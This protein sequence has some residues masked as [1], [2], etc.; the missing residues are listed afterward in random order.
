MNV[1]QRSELKLQKLIKGW[2]QK[3]KTNGGLVMI[4]STILTTEMTVTM[5]TLA[6]CAEH[7]A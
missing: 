4:T 5:T 2:L 3:N 1:A 6:R 7:K